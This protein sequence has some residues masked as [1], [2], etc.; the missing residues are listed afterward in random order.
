MFPVVHLDDRTVSMGKTIV[1][2]YGQEKGRLAVN[3]AGK[4]RG[5]PSAQIHGRTT[6]TEENAKPAE[7]GFSNEGRPAAERAQAARSVAPRKH[8]RTHPGDAPR[9]AA[10]CSA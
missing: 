1:R 10:I 9:Q 2:W 7:N 6:R 3:Y 5:Y 8:L 4:I